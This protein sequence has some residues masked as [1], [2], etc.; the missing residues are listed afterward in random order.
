MGV[1]TPIEIFCFSQSLVIAIAVVWNISDAYLREIV[2]T[3]CLHYFSIGEAI[4]SLYKV[5]AIQEAERTIHHAFYEKTMTSYRFK[6]IGA[7]G[8]IISKVIGP[9]Y[10]CR[11]G[12]LGKLKHGPVKFFGRN[13]YV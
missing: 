2:S 7:T 10:K 11:I 13:G 9:R 3:D 4:C 5:R 1:L 6:R 12:Y 8:E